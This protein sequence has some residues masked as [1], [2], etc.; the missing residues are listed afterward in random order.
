MLE[1]LKEYTGVIHIHTNYSDG[2]VRL[3]T[4]AKNRNKDDKEFKDS[5][6]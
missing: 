4:I 3:K 5:L 1:K 6:F 2:F